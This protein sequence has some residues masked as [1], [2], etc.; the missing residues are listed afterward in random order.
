MG[1]QW[2]SNTR[3]KAAWTTSTPSI[4]IRP[5]TTVRSSS[6]SSW[7]GALTLSLVLGAARS[8][9]AHR[10]DEYLQATRLAIEPDRVEIA[11][12]LTPGIAVAESIVAEIDAD[13]NNS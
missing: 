1:R 9:S 4:G 13:G 7:I 10:L 3:R 11:L 6:Q 5:T 8:T 2:S 12:D